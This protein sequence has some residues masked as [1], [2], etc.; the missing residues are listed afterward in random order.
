MGNFLRSNLFRLRLQ[1]ALR[2]RMGL[3][4]ISSFDLRKL[5]ILVLRVELG[6]DLFVC[7]EWARL[8]MEI[9]N[10]GSPKVAG[11]ARCAGIP[12]TVRVSIFGNLALLRS[13]EVLLGISILW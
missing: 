13:W 5:P 3:C 6:G 4:H 8:K 12:Y 11:A 10:G 9:W 2:V 7:K 1:S